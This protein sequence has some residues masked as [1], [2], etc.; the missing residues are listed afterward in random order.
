MC[1]ELSHLSHYTWKPRHCCSYMYKSQFSC[2][3][4]SVRVEGWGGG[5]GDIH[6]L[7]T[8]AILQCV[9]FHCDLLACIKNT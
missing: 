2:M 5:V 8:L 9:N 4:L 1:Y 7:C 3:L 6:H